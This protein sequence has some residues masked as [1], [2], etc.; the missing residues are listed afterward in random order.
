MATCCAAASQ[1]VGASSLRP[2]DQGFTS[3]TNRR[4]VIPGPLSSS[5]CRAGRAA[6]VAPPSIPSIS[7]LMC[8]RVAS[9]DACLNGA[10]LLHG[11]RVGWVRAQSRGAA[12]LAS[13]GTASI[14]KFSAPTV[15]GF[16]VF[17]SQV[18]IQNLKLS[19]LP[20]PAGSGRTQPD[21]RGAGGH[22]KDAAQRIDVKA[23]D[24]IV[25]VAV[26]GDLDRDEV[27]MPAAAGNKGD[28]GEA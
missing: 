5:G 24:V 9:R 16:P 13:F 6:R 2:S 7:V 25:S 21:F 18:S 17:S 19:F 10:G 15:E 12:P 28:M 8:L 26:I 23:R 14:T 27:A 1:K 22:G 4:P 3:K 20:V 11:G